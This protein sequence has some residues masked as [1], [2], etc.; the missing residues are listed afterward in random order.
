MTFLAFLPSSAQIQ[1]PSPAPE[2]PPFKIQVKVDAVLVPVVVRDSQGHAVGSLKKENFQIFD[3][4]Q[5][6]TISGFTVQQ[7]A[8]VEFAADNATSPAY[9]PHSIPSDSARK[10]A[11]SPQRFIVFLF[12]DLHFNNSDLAQVQT[13]VTRMLTGS[14]APSDMADVVSFSGVNSGLTNDHAL[15]QKTILKL[16]PQELYR[17]IGRQCPDVDYFLADQIINKHSQVAFDSAVQDTMTCANLTG[18]MRRLAEQ[19][20]QSAA[21]QSLAVGDQDVRL[22]L[23]LVKEIVH[24]MA[25]LPGQRT[26]ILISPGFLSTSADGMSLKSQILDEAAQSNVTVSALDAR[27]LYTT[28]LDASQHGENSAYALATG[29]SSQN[30]RES[31]SI[32]EDVMAELADGTGGTFFHNSNDLEGGFKS[33]AIAPEFIYLLELSL[34]NIKPNGTYH[35][36]KVKVDQKDLHLQARRGY[37][38]PLPPK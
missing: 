13:A 36:L 6:Q 16:K 17:H 24:K 38:A 31:M 25:V 30:H 19:M 5:L 35:H 20:A 2:P 14:L 11:I 27:G 22:S 18:D 26:L 1:N 23:G 32:N 28:N 4:G 10:A 3:Q 8:P 34:Q 29:Q 37:F 9:D 12:D 15:L 7:R 21:S 33:L